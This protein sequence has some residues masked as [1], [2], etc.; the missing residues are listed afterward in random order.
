MD[1]YPGVKI[2]AGYMSADN[3]KA[4]HFSETIKEAETRDN[5][6]GHLSEKVRTIAS[7]PAFPNRL[8][9]LRTVVAWTVLV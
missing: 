7:V 4:F 1:I 8:V 6:A 9:N 5:C 2:N 3:K